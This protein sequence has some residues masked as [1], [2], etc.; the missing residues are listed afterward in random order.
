MKNWGNRPWT[1]DFHSTKCELPRSVDFAVVGGGFTGLA[2]AAWLKH[3]APRKSVA[4]FES[5]SFG[6][7]SSG[8]TGG[9]ALAETATGDLP[10]LC[11]VLAGYQNILRTLDVQ[12]CL[13]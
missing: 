7:G 10:G 5:E 13:S 9:L 3:L 2:A 11:D 6:A 1:I 12:A 8:H 4:L